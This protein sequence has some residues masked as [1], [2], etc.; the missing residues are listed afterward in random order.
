MFIYLSVDLTLCHPNSAA[1]N[2]G[3]IIKSIRD[4]TFEYEGKEPVKI[5]WSQYDQAQI[6]ELANYLD[7]IRDLVDES[8]KRIKE[9][10]P[11]QK[12]PRHPTRNI[13]AH[14]ETRTEPLET[15]Q[16]GNPC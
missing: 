7:T 9:R 15:K 11:Q 16:L 6:M 12:H 1:K 13:P 14:V 5:N 10:T 4:E 8:Y 3:G 2:H